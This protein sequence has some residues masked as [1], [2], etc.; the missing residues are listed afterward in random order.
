[1]AAESTTHARRWFEDRAVIRQLPLR[2]RAVAGYCR[3]ADRVQPKRMRERGFV[4]G[5]SFLIRNVAKAASL[6]GA[7]NDVMVEVDGV[8]IACDVADTRF[9]HV[10]GEVR[11]SG[12]E[13]RIYSAL[14][15]PGDAF[16]DVGANHGSFSVVASR[17]IGRDGT[18]VAFEPQAH[19]A[20]LIRKSLAQTVVRDATVR[21]VAVG[22]SPGTATLH[23][24]RAM[25]GSA[26]LHQGALGEGPQEHQTIQIVRLD[27]V[28]A[29]FAPT[30]KVVM[31][32]D[33]E[34]HELDALRG[35]ER[36]LER[37]R[38]V[39]VLE[40]NPVT[41]EGAG[42]RPEEILGFLADL[43]YRFAEYA[44]FPQTV[45]AASM[46]TSYS[47]N[48]VAVPGDGTTSAT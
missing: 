43:G 9:V 6:A 11:R 28:L 20:E 13:H 4:V 45:D 44:T 37:L 5:S 48:V 18:I 22:S 16:L 14:L 25:S 41:T 31:K 32:L 46:D 19:L 12:D 3:L 7:S 2:L 34:G 21:A 8:K 15:G 26:T 38:P 27:D 17:L 30:G 33:V 35:A 47:R 29:D 10:L 42:R 40:L 36:T 39:I 23:I 1:M 24:P